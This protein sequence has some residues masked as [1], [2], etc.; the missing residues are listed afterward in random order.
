LTGPVEI[1]FTGDSFSVE[2]DE[3]FRSGL[4][5]AHDGSGNFWVLDRA[6][7]EAG[8]VFFLCHDPPVVLYQSADLETCLSEPSLDR[9]ALLTVWRTN[10]GTLDHA[11]ALAGDDE[12]RAFAEALDDR[13]VF[14][15]LRAPGSGDGF[16][17]G[18]YGPR[19][20]LR[21]HGSA[22]LFACAEPEQKP[23][24]RLFGRRSD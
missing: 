22:R 7:A 11:A 20:E 21:R 8:P 1:D 6:P 18:R 19:T 4:P 23:R 12:L 13:F 14:V 3:L 10:P 15:D 16:A 2:L 5:I 24:R 9:D 17:W